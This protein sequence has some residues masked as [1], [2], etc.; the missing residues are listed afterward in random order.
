MS[1]TLP[2]FFFLQ[3]GVGDPNRFGNYLTLGYALMWLAGAVYVISLLTRQA[4]IQ[5]DLQLLK[6][7]LDEDEEDGA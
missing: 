1:W 3:A 2:L 5:K 4:N 6:R 7:L